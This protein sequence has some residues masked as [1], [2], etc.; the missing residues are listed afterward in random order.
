MGPDLRLSVG[1]GDE[2]RTRVSSLGSWHGEGL[3]RSIVLKRETLDAHCD[4]VPTVR[5]CTLVARVDAECDTERWR[6]RKA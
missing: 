2:N 1:A 5:Y 4:P 3:A 6:S